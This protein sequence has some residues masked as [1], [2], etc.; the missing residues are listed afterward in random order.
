MTICPPTTFRGI[1]ISWSPPFPA[2]SALSAAMWTMP[3]R[4]KHVPIT[5]DGKLATPD[6]TIIDTRYPWMVVI[7]VLYPPGAAPIS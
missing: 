6:G 7:K 2:N 3:L 5:Q 1:A 4:M